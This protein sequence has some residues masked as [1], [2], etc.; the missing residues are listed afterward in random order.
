MCGIAGWISWSQAPEPGVVAAMTEALHH[1]GPDGGAVEALGPAVLGHRRLAIIDPRPESDQPFSDPEQR[2]WLTFNGEIYNFRDL[3]RALEEQGVAFR[4]QGDTEVVLEAFKAW[5]E[6]FVERLV[7]QFALAIWDAERQRLLLARDRAGEKPLFY[8]LLRDGGLVFASEPGALR[9][10]PEVDRE[11]DP[12][13]LAEYLALNYTIGERTLSNEVKRLPPA[14]VMVFA[15]GDSPRLRRYWD[16]AEAFRNKRR[17]ESESAAAGE[18][19]ALLDQ[20]VSSQMI[21]DVP[22]GAF[23]SGGIDSSAVVASMVRLRPPAEVQTFSMGFA[24]KSYSELPEAERAARHL[25]VTHRDRVVSPEP[26]QVASA[27]V[28]AADEPL[29]DSS[30]VPMY[31]LAAHARETVTVALSGDG[32]DEC[33]A[34]YETYL[35][36]RLHALVRHLPRAVTAGLTGAVERFWPVSHDKVSFDYKLRRFLQGQALPPQEAHLSWRSIFDPAERLALMQP[37]WRAAV[38]AATRE[39]PA[40]AIRHFEAVAGCHPLDQALYVDFMTWLPGDILVKVD[41]MTMAHSLEAR[42]PFLDHR[43]V[44]F[45]AALPTS[46]KLKGLRMKHLLKQSQRDRLPAWLLQRRKQ[47]FNAPIS[48]WLQGPLGDF[49]RDALGSETLTTWFRPE[50]ISRLWDEHKSQRRD[51]GLRLLSLLSVALWLEGMRAS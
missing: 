22:L 39:P 40:E 42:A 3:R 12:L 7:G 26:E 33:F 10:H 48:A 20:A 50:Q 16:P 46:W 37:D 24:E 47:G 21:S 25:G 5:G 35:A 11:I 8:Q 31:Y 13:A 1:R 34:G 38:E 15:H 30:A 29:A 51:N 44:E 28:R 36:D 32:G 6:R 4:T 14:H 18:L 45:A 23:L 49:A 41:R 17:F 19:N 27:L 43:L 2:F 9:R